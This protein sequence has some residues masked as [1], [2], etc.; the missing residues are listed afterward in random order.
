MYLFL[1]NLGVQIDSSQPL[2]VS[3]PDPTSQEIKPPP[4]I[5]SD[6][7]WKPLPHGPI[8]RPAESVSKT[9]P[10]NPGVVPEV[11]TAPPQLSLKDKPKE[12]EVRRSEIL[13]GSSFSFNSSNT[14]SM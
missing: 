5:T 1:H 14:M 9:Q 6:N 4:I 12:D 8:V 7:Q 10:T 13:A 3:A 11:V 2:D